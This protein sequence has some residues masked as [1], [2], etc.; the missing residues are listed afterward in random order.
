MLAALLWISP[1]LHSISGRMLRRFRLD[2]YAGWS[3]S[4]VLTLDASPSGAG[5]IL[6]I[7]GVIEAWFSSAL[8]SED[9]G[10][11]QTGWGEP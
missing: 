1:F 2:A 3:S 11:L 8:T 9:E 7:D 6:M 10:D 4:V 5:G